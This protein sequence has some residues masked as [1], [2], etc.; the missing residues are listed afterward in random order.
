MTRPARSAGFALAEG[1]PGFEFHLAETL[2]RT[3]AELRATMANDEYQE[4]RAFYT[5]RN[6][7]AEFEVA[8]AKAKR[9]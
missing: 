7:M 9:R 1:D 2:G 4:W 5:W 6:A 3:V 8:K